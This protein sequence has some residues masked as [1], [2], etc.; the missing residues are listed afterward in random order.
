M[1]TGAIPSNVG[2]PNNMQGTV[3]R[4]VTRQHTSEDEGKTFEDN[5]GRQYVYTSKGL[6][7]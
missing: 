6:M 1:K 7:Y 4:A 5:F 2:F 3:N